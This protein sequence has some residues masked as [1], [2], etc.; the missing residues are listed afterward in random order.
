M[1]DILVHNN[2][3][4]RFISKYYKMQE[5]ALKIL[6]GFT[7]KVIHERHDELIAKQSSTNNAPDD[8][9]GIGIK[10]KVAFLDMLL[11]TTI[12]GKP[13]TNLEI[14]EEVDTFMFEVIKSIIIIL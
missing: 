10:R 5:N 13:L 6:H 14:R 1:F 3:Y 12:D 8:G 9:D 4:F 11:Q 7:D 2:F